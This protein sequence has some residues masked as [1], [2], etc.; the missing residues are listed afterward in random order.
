MRSYNCGLSLNFKIQLSYP[1]FFSF[2]V[3]KKLL[4][5]EGVVLG[6]FPT[7]KNIKFAFSHR[8]KNVYLAKCI[9]S[10]KTDPIFFRVAI[11][12]SRNLTF[13]LAA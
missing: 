11:F 2:F 10:P 13:V 8:K 1:H 3:K 12:C 7:K 9:P 4:K 6:L 5:G